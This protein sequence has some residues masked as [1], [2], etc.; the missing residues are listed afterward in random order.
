MK[1]LLIIISS[2]L[3]GIAILL[4]GAGLY[5]NANIEEVT[6]KHLGATIN[7]EDVE[8][9]YSPMPTVVFTKLEVEHKN[10]K[11][12]IPSLELYPDL[13]DLVRGRISLKKAVLE[14]PLV[15]ADFISKRGEDK[16]PS[17][18][19]P[20]TTA[21]I[22]AERL[23]GLTINRG[24][25]LL[26]APNS[27][28]QPISFTVAM[29]NIE[30]K[31]QAISVQLKQFSV[32]EIGLKFAG[33]IT[34]SSFAPLKLKVDAPEASINPSAV[35]DFL[36]KFGFIKKELGTQIPKIESVG[37]KGLRL[38]I[39][40]DAGKFLLS[41]AALSFDQNSL[42]D[43]KINLSE[44][45][46]FELTCAQIL[47]DMR[48]IQGW[49]MDNPKGKEAVDNLLAKAKLKSLTTEGKVQLSSLDIKGT[50]GKE[51]SINGSLD[52]RTQG[53]KI[54]LVSETGEKQS[55]TVNQLDTK[56]TVRQGK[57]SV[58]VGKLQLSSSRGGTG[59]ITG[60]FALPLDL[61]DIEFRGSLDSFK[62]FDSVV[63][64]DATKEKRRKRLTFDLDLTSPSLGVLAKGLVRVPLHNKTDFVARLENFRVSKA[65]SEKPAKPVKAEGE[66]PK[67]FD[68]TA[69][70]GKEISAEASIKSFQFNEL[71]ELE[72]VE[73]LL[74]CQNDKAVVRGKIRLCSTDILVNAVLIP[75]SRVT[76][77]IEGRAVGLDLTSFIACFSKE[78]PVFL[79]GK[80]SVSA[81]L[82][83]TGTNSKDLLDTA[84]GEVVVTL[85]RCSVYRLSN[86]DYR[87]SFLLDILGVAGI[88]PD[89]IDS[90]AFNKAIAKANLRKGRV[91]FDS[92][93]L[94]GPIVDAWGSGEF[95]LKE[96]RLRLSGQVRTALGVTK[97]LDI[98]RVLKRR[99]I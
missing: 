92:F 54:N 74:R 76:A 21:V 12:R 27:Q 44:K 24:K 87:L 82:F 68:L 88:N 95:L 23:G 19:V 89:S 52:L 70:K 81:S 56:I 50:Q 49:L 29:E 60:S 84:E 34:V 53:L 36:V 69:V 94:R 83:A 85:A 90:I 26:K 2:S 1:K 18:S 3:L 71:P 41:S 31:D 86:L 51:A 64:L 15:L 98:D 55:F 38:E 4:F 11:V 63:S 5:I 78:L 99:N 14:E 33:D 46:A 66:E 43:T 58:K 35:K 62:V 17:G 73:F 75:P 16:G 28:P 67:D 42:K 91:V 20:L 80:I 65:G 25:L 77:Q 61:K 32:K 79:T 48:T 40:P 8:F 72:D 6:R 10:N 57:P 7:F 59:T 45:G 30:K 97:G 22:P 37:S 93:S 39:D 96:K 13:M 9:R 47:L